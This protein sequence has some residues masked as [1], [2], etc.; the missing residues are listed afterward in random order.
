MTIY[1]APV[2]DIDFVLNEVLDYQA[3]YK[4]IPAGAEATPDMVEAI[5]AEAAKFAE[6]VLS[7]LN[8]S[9]DL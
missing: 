9:G 3:H 4:T 2:R 5:T 1:K 7:P 6:E 8:Q